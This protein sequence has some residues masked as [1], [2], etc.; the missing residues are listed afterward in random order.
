MKKMGILIGFVLVASCKSIAPI[1]ASKTVDTSLRPRVVQ[2]QVAANALAF[3]TLQWRGQ[4]ALAQRGK[5]QKISITLR[6]NKEEG[7]WING[8][9]IVPLARVLITP[10]Q[11]QF[12]EKIN[13]Q[14]AQID[15][16]QLQKLLGVPVGYKMIERMLTAAPLDTRALKRSK[17]TFTENAYVFKYRKKDVTLEWTYDTSFRLVEQLFSD[18]ETSI[19]IAYDAYTRISNQWVPQQLSTMILGAETSATLTLRAKQTQLNKPFK[20][21]FVIPEGYKQLE[22]Q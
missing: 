17:L 18:G 5:S 4:A 21:P 14:Y 7:I 6:L 15:Y 19:R 16:Q 22:I 11:L 8:S 3:E 13:R 10:E 1:V 2:Q 20:M 9:V 12:Y